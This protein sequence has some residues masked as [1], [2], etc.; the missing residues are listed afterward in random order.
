MAKA[1]Q[2]QASADRKDALQTCNDQY[3]ARQAVC[4]RLGGAPYDPPIE[5]AN[6]VAKIDNPYFPLTP[7]TMFIYEGQTAQGLEHEEFFVTYNT[8][9]ILGVTCIVICYL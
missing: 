9:M 5:P 8:R 4:Q 6:F 2:Q 1:C 3:D 7:G